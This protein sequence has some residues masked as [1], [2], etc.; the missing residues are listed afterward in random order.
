MYTKG[1]NDV[2][3]VTPLFGVLF[4]LAEAMYCLRAPFMNVALAAGKYKETRNGSIIE[5]AIWP[6]WLGNRHAGRNGV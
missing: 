2:D 3:Y 4:M 5:M 1:V 6:H